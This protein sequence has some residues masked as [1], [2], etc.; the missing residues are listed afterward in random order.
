MID[1]STKYLGLELDNPLVP[2]AGPPSRS[3]EMAK[4]LE[5]AG[6]AALVMES[7]FEEQILHEQHE[8]YWHTTHGTESFA[9]SLSYFPE[10]G[11]YVVSG[12]EYLE[13]IFRLKSALKIPVI[14]SLNGQSLGGWTR[15]ANLLEQAGADAIE[16]NIYFLASDAEETAESVENRYLEILKAVRR[17]VTIPIAVKLGPFF[18]AF[19]HMAHQLDAAG[20]DGLVLFNR[21]YQPDIDLEEM[22]VAP[23]VLLSTPQA[24]RLPLRWIAI[25]HGRLRASLAATGGVHTAQ[26][27]AKMLLVGADATQMVSALL[28]RGPTHVKHVLHDLRAWM[29]ERGMESVHQ[30]K[31]SMSYRNVRDS[32]QFE[33]ANY[34]K[35]LK[36]YQ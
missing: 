33:R 24:M 1:L 28:E 4:R 36:S 19:A 27:V 25:L 5:D 7:L 14:A 6:A 26:D 22:E 21:F 34:M 17:S 30:M 12:E 11:A 20:A 29:E 15:Y 16:L 31:G 23:N 3:L 32:S 2:G 18:S 35:A 13:H 9:E 8:L 10:H